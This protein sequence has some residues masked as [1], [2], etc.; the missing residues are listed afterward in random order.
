MTITETTTLKS[1]FTQLWPH[2]RM[3]DMEW[4]VL[5]EKAAKIDVSVEQAT[6]VL[7]ELKATIGPPPNVA[8]VLAAL[9]GAQQARGPYHQPQQPGEKDT[10]SWGYRAAEMRDEQGLT[11]FERRVLDDQEFEKYARKAGILTSDRLKEI[12]AKVTAAHAMEDA[13]F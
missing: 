10:R 2:S 11:S 12:K 6:A 1:L 8:E 9:K 3:T 7:R 13:P 4:G 5:A